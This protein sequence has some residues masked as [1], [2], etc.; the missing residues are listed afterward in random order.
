MRNIREARLRFAV[1]VAFLSAVC[2]GAACFL[3]SPIGAS[4]RARRQELEH[5][6]AELRAKA[7]EAQASRG[8]DQKVIVAKDQVAEFYQER[9]PKMIAGGALLVGAPLLFYQRLHT[10]ASGPE[11]LKGPVAARS[12]TAPTKSRSRTN[13]H[14]YVAMLLKPTLDPRL[15]LDLLAD[16]E[17]IKYDGTGRNIFANDRE[18]IPKPIAPVVVEGDKQPDKV[19]WQPPVSPPPPINLKFWGWASKAGE[20]KAVFLAQ[21]GNGFVALLGDIVANRYRVVQISTTSLGI[22][23]MLSNNRHSVPIA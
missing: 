19:L 18:D 11:A 16:S 17:G 9:K 14:R 13:E 8:I 1:I 21:G 7:L 4:P 23:S 6:R 2:L 15:R 3:L 10:P 5:L 12:A 22:T 20:S